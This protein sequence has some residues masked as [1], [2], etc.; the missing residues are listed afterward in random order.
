MTLAQFRKLTKELP[1]DTRLIVQG[2]TPNDAQENY[3]VA[4][5]LHAPEWSCGDVKSKA[6]VVRTIRCEPRLAKLETLGD[7]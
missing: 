4:A 6:L 3:D 1:D 7:K 2:T 5:L